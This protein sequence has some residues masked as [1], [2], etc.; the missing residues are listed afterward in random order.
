MFCTNNNNLI[1]RIQIWTHIQN[2]WQ[3]DNITGILKLRIKFRTKPPTCTHV[4]KDV[5]CRLMLDGGN[6]VKQQ[7]KIKGQQSKT[8]TNQTAT[9]FWKSGKAETL[10]SPTVAVNHFSWSFTAN[11]CR[12]SSEQFNRWIRPH[13]TYR[14]N[15]WWPYH[16]L[17]LWFGPGG[18][19]PHLQKGGK[20]FSQPSRK[21]A[22]ELIRHGNAL[23][24]WRWCFKLWAPYFWVRRWI[25]CCCRFYSYNMP[26]N[27]TDSDRC[28]LGH[29]CVVEICY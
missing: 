26:I 17:V 25:F 27:I 19:R 3:L 29:I 21:Q 10:C 9:G 11:K 13:R 5:S 1:Y 23:P 6:A 7:G 15:F 8:A 14:H 20:D 4:W 12:K 2:R 28:T 18:T 22:P 24:H 16:I